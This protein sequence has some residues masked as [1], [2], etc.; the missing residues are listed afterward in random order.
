MIVGDSH[1]VSV[2]FLVD[3]LAN[4]LR[5]LVAPGLNSQQHLVAARLLHCQ[6]HLFAKA[7]TPHVRDPRQSEVL[8]RKQ[9]TELQANWFQNRERVVIKGDLSDPVILSKQF[10]LLDHQFRISRT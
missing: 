8:S 7:V 9:F 5:D 1:R 10:N 2:S 3:R 4:P 6:S